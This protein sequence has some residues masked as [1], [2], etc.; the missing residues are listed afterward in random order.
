[1]VVVWLCCG[2]DMVVV[3]LGYSCDVG[4][5]LG[6]S[7]D[8]VMRLCCGFALVVLV[9]QLHE[10]DVCVWKQEIEYQNLD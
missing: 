10:N 6:C 9:L 8:M 1:M 3:W 2:C 4:V 5:G 7:C